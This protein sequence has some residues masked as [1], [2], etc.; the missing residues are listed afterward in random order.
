MRQA[1]LE[2]IANGSVSHLGDISSYLG[3][4]LL[5]AI[6]AD[7]VG[8]PTTDDPH[9]PSSISRWLCLL[10]CVVRAVKLS[11]TIPGSSIIFSFLTSVIEVS[12]FDRPMLHSHFLCIAWCRSINRTF[13]FLQHMRFRI[14]SCCAP[15][16]QCRA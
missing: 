6:H 10:V 4:T 15:A 12:C 5:A 2:A 11:H 1:M 3:C 9:S 16:H 8:C 7:P 14:R 13:L